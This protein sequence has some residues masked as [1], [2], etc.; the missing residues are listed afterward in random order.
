MQE[1]TILGRL[2]SFARKDP[3]LWH[4][5]VENKHSVLNSDWLESRGCAASSL[6]AAVD[7]LMNLLGSM[8]QTRPREPRKNSNLL[9][10]GE[11]VN[12]K[13]NLK[14]TK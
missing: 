11:T 14:L 10:I 3:K 4:S 7:K 5:Q 9:H 6:I 2:F 1:N 12:Y 8:S 13:R